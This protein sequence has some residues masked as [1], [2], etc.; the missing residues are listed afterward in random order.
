M[1]DDVAMLAFKNSTLK[2]I[3]PVFGLR[4]KKCGPGGHNTREAKYA[5]TPESFLA[6]LAH[7]ETEITK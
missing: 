7:K 3:H 4:V 6:P 1:F 2:Y 5:G